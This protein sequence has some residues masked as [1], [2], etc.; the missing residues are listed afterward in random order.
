VR[1]GENRNISLLILL[2][3]V[4]YL[5]GLKIKKSGI[6][7]CGFRMELIEMHLQPIKELT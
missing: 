4:D 5:Y 2:L 1:A 7:Q 6:I 3:P